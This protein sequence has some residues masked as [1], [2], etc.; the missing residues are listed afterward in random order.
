MYYYAGFAA[1]Y[2]AGLTAQNQARGPYAGY[3]NEVQRAEAYDAGVRDAAISLAKEKAAAPYAKT[4]GTEAEFVRDDYVTGLVERGELDAKTVDRMDAAA[5]LL[6]VRARMV[7]NV[8]E[9]RAN[10]GYSGSDILIAKDAADPVAQVFGHE[11]A[12][13]MQELAPEQFRVFR[14]AAMDH[15]ADS[16]ARAKID[17]YRAQGMTIQYEAAMDDVAADYAG[18]LME[19]GQVLDEFIDRHRTDRSL[20][21]KLRDA[22][23]RLVAK[24]T[25]ADRR[26]AQ[27]AE[28]KL[29]AALDAAAEQAGKLQPGTGSQTAEGDVKYSLKEFTDSG[30]KLP[31]YEELIKKPDIKGVAIR[32]H[33]KTQ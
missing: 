17:N 25:G 28:G 4:A 2:Q 5:R 13:R 29:S 12:H 11:L 20:L 3:I 15:M 19:N 7:D 6:G 10:G 21:E 14:Q 1:W 18:Q 30:R 8:A 33:E 23:R 9:A 22:F 32:K 16:A 24:L 27:T 31:T 26:K